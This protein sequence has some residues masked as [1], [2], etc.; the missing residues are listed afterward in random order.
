MLAASSAVW[1][2]VM[3]CASSSA[4]DAGQEKPKVT[5]ED[6]V[7]PI[8]GI[9]FVRIVV[10]LIRRSR[11]FVDPGANHTLLFCRQRRT[12]FGHFV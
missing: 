11:A 3:S 8:L 2:A 6:H 5:F 9:E 1:L 12:T 4:D 7:L 10:R